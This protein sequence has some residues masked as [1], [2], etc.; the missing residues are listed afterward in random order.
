MNPA[1]GI[2]LARLLDFAFTLAEAGIARGPYVEKAS[3]M[4]AAGASPD[5]ITD[6]LQKM[7]QES[8]AEAQKKIDGAA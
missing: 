6:A 4:A 8:E 1:A 3:Q 2:A 7:R 5:E